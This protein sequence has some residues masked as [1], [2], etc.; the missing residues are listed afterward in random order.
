[1]KRVGQTICKM[2]QEPVDVR[3]NDSG[4]RYISIRDSSRV[5]FCY[6]DD[7][8]DLFVD[9]DIGNDAIRDIRELLL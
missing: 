7:D 8:V 1:M 3:V 4:R 5:H 2:C 9:R 6:K